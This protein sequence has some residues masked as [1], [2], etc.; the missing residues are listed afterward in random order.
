MVDYPS[1]QPMFVDEQRTFINAAPRAA[2]VIHKTGGTPDIP[3][4]AHYFQT[5]PS[6]K[7]S[8]YGIGQDGTVAQFVLEKDGAAANCCVEA[9]YDPFWQPYVNQ[10]INLNLCTISIEHCIQRSTTA[11]KDASF[12]LVAYLAKKYNIA[13]DRIKGHH[14]IDP[15][16]RTRCPGN[17][18]WDELWAHL[19]GST[20]D[21][22]DPVVAGY[23]S[24]TP[25]GQWQCKRTGYIVQ[26]GILSFYRSYGQDGTVD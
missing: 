14:T 12:K 17:Y 22:T 26:K 2:I 8:H 4:L 19:K 20:I 21:L 7:S 11:Q 16:K 13:P 24:A 9:G 5:D 6:M 25:G 18:P 23:F 3:S 10:Y 15:I 1:A